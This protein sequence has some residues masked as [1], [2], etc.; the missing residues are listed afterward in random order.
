M[1]DSAMIFRVRWWIESYTDTR[2]VYD[3]VNTALQEAMDGAHF[4]ETYPTQRLLLELDPDTAEQFSQK[5]PKE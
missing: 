2:H 4:K 5:P 3:L 1:G